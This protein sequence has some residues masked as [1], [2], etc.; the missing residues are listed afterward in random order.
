MKHS[1]HN[2]HYYHHHH[3]G[4]VFVVVDYLYIH[5][6]LWRTCQRLVEWTVWWWREYVVRV[7]VIYD[8][9]GMMML[10]IPLLFIWIGWWLIINNHFVG[11]WVSFFPETY[12]RFYC[13][14][15][16][17]ELNVPTLINDLAWCTSRE[18][19]ESEIEPRTLELPKATS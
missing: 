2:D 19:V 10:G 5:Q 15:L 14:K 13:N 17:L 6:R 1:H 3:H 7:I 16:Q 11:G 4:F 12:S 9:D 8:D 18:R